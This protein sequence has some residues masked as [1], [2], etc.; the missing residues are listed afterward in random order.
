MIE[1]PFVIAVAPNGARRTKAD[2]PTLPM[3]AE[4]LVRT[5]RECSE[6][7]AA[8]LHLHVRDSQGKHSLSPDLYRPAL[9]VLEKEVGERMV[10]QVSSEA[11]GIYSSSEQ[12]ARME[13]LAPNCL[14]IGLREIFSEQNTYQ[15]GFGFLDRLYRAGV[16]IQYIL[17]SPQE[18][19]WYEMLCGE[20]VIPG[21]RHFLLFVLG[22]YASPDII[23]YPLPAYLDALQTPAHWMA[24][25]FGRVEAEIARQAAELGG[26]IRVGFENN[27]F[28][29]DGSMARTNSDLID[30]AVLNG[31][32]A[33]RTKGAREDAVNLHRAVR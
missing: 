25:G 22:S 8:M 24:C 13:E 30:L 26:H 15:A 27:L 31:I 32:E 10:L 17:Y 20:G 12:I 14:S 11:A 3:T 1:N 18:V 29:P 19:E 16:L 5:A 33:G 23:P 6:A 21:S 4:E 7:G 9:E 28:L 2:H